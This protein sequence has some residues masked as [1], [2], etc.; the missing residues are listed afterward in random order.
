MR[1]WIAI[2][3]GHQDNMKMAIIHVKVSY[4]LGQ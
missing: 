3:N 2:F 1:M 4:F